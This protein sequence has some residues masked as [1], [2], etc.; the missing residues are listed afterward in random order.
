M[1]MLTA[2]RANPI[3]GGL[4]D[5]WLWLALVVVFFGFGLITQLTLPIAD[6]TA[7]YLVTAGALLDGGR[8]Y[9]T[10]YLDMNTPIPVAIAVPSV[11]LSRLVGLSAESLFV[12]F[13][14]ALIMLSSGLLWSILRLDPAPPL[15]LRRGLLLAAV[16]VCT[17]SPARDFTQREHIMLV[18]ALP[19]FVLLARRAGGLSDAGWFAPLVGLLAAVGFAIKPHY[20][21]IPAALELYLLFRC[22]R[23]TGFLRQ[24]TISLAAVVALLAVAI[25]WLTPEYLEKIIPFAMVVY[26]QGHRVAPGAVLWRPESAML[27]IVVMLHLSTRRR[28]AVPAY[29]DVLVLAS[30]CFYALFVA[31]MK[32]WSYHVYPAVGSMILAG[33]GVIAGGAFRSNKDDEAPIMVSPGRRKLCSALVILLAV[34]GLVALRGQYRTPHVERMVSSVRQHAAGQAISALT[35]DIWVGF[36]LVNMT[37]TRWASRFPALWPLPGLQRARLDPDLSAEQTKRLDEIEHYIRSAINEDLEQRKPVLLLVD[38]QPHN[39]AFGDRKLSLLEFFSRDPRF[40]EIFSRYRKVDQIG[41]LAIYK[42][43][44]V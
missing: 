43:A 28:Q 14:F 25:L 37:G 17:V 31:Q 41:H 6:D 13:T 1:T 5:G 16:L 34:A 26:E 15:Q 35:G 20:L 11:F 36:P 24:E 42:L 33:L 9:D 22:R 40:A 38:V 7:W 21:V 12:L 10:I 8:L 39:P 4:V 19:Y 30:I 32:G 23:W 18:L 3:P 2:S 27:L 44:G 29:V